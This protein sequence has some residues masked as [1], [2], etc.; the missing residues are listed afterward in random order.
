MTVS[1]WFRLLGAGL[2]PRRPGLD[3]G[4]VHV[5]FVIDKVALKQGFLS[6]LRL[7]HQYHFNNAP[8]SYYVSLNKTFLSLSVCLSSQDDKQ[9]SRVMQLDVLW[10]FESHVS[11]SPRTLNWTPLDSNGRW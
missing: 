9:P 2:S 8:A 3:P 5:V 10:L 11:H 7:F 6:V 4:P 1:S